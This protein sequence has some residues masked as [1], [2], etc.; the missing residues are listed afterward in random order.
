MFASK[1]I[2]KEEDSQLMDQAVHTQHSGKNKK[3][4]AGT[5]QVYVETLKKHVLVPTEETIRVPV[6]RKEKISNTKQHVVQGQK[7]IPIKKFKEVEET[8]MEVKGEM[9]DGRWEKRAV[10]VKKMKKIPFME[11]EAQPVEVVVDV[12][13]EDVVTRTGYRTDKHV[14]NKVMVVEEDHVYEMQ[15]VYKG[16]AETRMKEGEDHHT[17][18]TFHGKPTWDNN[19][20]EGWRGR[21]PTPPYR[22]DLKAFERPTTANTIRPS[23]AGSS[24]PGSVASRPASVCSTRPGSAS[25][26]RPRPASAGSSRSVSSTSSRPGSASYMRPRPGSTGNAAGRARVDRLRRSFSTPSIP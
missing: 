1:R 20:Y 22:P 8:V 10:P 6:V 13:W 2:T 17:F 19:A 4:F 16:K 23:S 26:M 15:P 18:K 11:Y 7:M 14:V 5:G 12:P 3:P 25:N 24:R 21:P 9:V